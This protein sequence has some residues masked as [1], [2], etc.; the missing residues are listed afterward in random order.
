MN[1]YRTL[2]GLGP[3]KATA[4]TVCQKCLKKGHYSYECKASTQE[5]PYMSRPSRTQQLLNPKLKPKLTSDAP[6]KLLTSKGVADQQLAETEASRQENL[7][8]ETEERGRSLR[9][10]APSRSRSLSSSSVSTISTN[11]SRSRSRALPSNP[12]DRYRADLR[13]SRSR[14]RTPT[15]KRKYRSV[16]GSYSRSS[17][18]PQR[19]PG[20]HRKSRRHR[21]ISP[22]DRGRSSRTRRGSRR[23]RTGSPSMD[24][25]QI[26]KHRVSME[27][28]NGHE[29][30]GRQHDRGNRW[31]EKENERF[32]QGTRT[33]NPKQ[34]ESRRERSLSP[35][36]KRLA[37]TQAMNL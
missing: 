11:R 5:R 22:I 34:R 13:A 29:D 28:Q 8:T 30:D 15:R 33:F 26:T 10:G 27:P 36:S 32:P 6:N 4:S 7:P 24:K 14:S 16:S 37:L 18:S 12:G 23:S 19:A 31:R 25:S 2:P 1:K 3:Q 9:H 21:T 35:Y 17:G 20:S